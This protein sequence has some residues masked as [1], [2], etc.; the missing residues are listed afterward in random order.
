MQTTHDRIRAR[1]LAPIDVYARATVGHAEP[2]DPWTLYT[3]EREGRALWWPEMPE[4]GGAEYTLD[5][6][7]AQEPEYVDL[8]DLD[9]GSPRGRKAAERARM[10]RVREL[11]RA[12]LSY[13]A[14]K[15]IDPALVGIEPAHDVS[16][17]WAQVSG[18]AERARQVQNDAVRAEAQKHQEARVERKEAGEGRG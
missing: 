14:M 13:N 10:E 17:G 15:P 16:V 18:Y 6:L 5:L 9:A 7:P 12:A 11:Q 1:L 2:P 3:V 4:P 8:E